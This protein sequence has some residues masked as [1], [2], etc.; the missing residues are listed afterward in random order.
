MDDEHQQH[1]YQN[2]VKQYFSGILVDNT[3]EIQGKG[4]AG[5]GDQ[6]EF[7][8]FNQFL[9]R[10]AQKHLLVPVLKQVDYQKDHQKNS[11]QNLH[12]HRVV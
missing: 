6:I 7:D 8:D 1:I 2:E 11:N 4:S 12:I 9:E 5:Q 3:G 10:S